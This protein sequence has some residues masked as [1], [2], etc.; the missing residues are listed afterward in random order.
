MDL[1]KMVEEFHRKH[2]AAISAVPTMTTP[3]ACRFRADLMREEL[4]EYETACAEGNMVEAYDALIDLL[5]VTV[6]SLVSHGFP[7]APGF[8]EVHASNM[9]KDAIKLMGTT[10]VQKGPNFRPPDLAKVLAAVGVRGA[11]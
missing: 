8:V 3:E 5:Y 2:G 4:G 6:G 7:L 10:K 9:T 1:Q 11:R